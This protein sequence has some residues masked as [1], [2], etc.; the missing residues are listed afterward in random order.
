MLYTQFNPFLSNINNHFCC[1]QLLLSLLIY[2]LVCLL[3]QTILLK[4]V[5]YLFFTLCKQQI[6]PKA[7]FQL[8]DK[9]V[10]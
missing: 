1:I 4:S 2:F 10:T 9:N 3:I 8:K 6:T 5:F 7:I